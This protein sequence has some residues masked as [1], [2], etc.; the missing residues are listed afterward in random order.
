MALAFKRAV[1]EAEKAVASANA[2][3]KEWYKPPVDPALVID[4]DGIKAVEGVSTQNPNSVEGP[5]NISLVN[6]IKDYAGRFHSIWGDIQYK[7]KERALPIAIKYIDRVVVH[8]DDKSPAGKYN[9]YAV[10]W[11]GKDVHVTVH[12]DFSN[13]PQ[14][15]SLTDEK[16]GHVDQMVWAHLDEVGNMTYELRKATAIGYSSSQL[17]TYQ[18]YLNDK[19]KKNIPLEVDWDSLVKLE[20]SSEEYSNKPPVPNRARAVT[21]LEDGRGFY[22]AY[23]AVETLVK[24]QLGLEAFLETFDKLHLSVAPGSTEVRSGPHSITK[25]GKTLKIQYKLNIG[26]FQ[27]ASADYSAMAKQIE[28]LL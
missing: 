13:Y 6:W 18:K 12:I 4:W 27:N 24:D 14:Q 20:G 3:I 8:M 16:G 15:L 5:K 9:T 19:L 23:Y 26:N 2:S 25:E 11:K 22:N 1:G 28:A 21:F 10:E 17:N 7:D